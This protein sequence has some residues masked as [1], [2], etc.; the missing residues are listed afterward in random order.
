RWYIVGLHRLRLQP[1]RYRY[2]TAH[3]EKQIRRQSWEG[4]YEFARRDIEPR[5]STAPKRF[6]D[7]QLCLFV[8]RPGPQSRTKFPSNPWSS[9]SPRSE[10]VKLKPS[11]LKAVYQTL[12]DKKIHERKKW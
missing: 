2:E 5:Q 11:Y 7:N 3:Q 1:R 10:F 8:Q 12:V 4:S 9:L 6:A